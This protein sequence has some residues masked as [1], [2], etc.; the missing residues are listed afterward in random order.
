MTSSR[1]NLVCSG[2]RGSFGPARLDVSVPAP[3][4]NAGQTLHQ[5]IKAGLDIDLSA[6]ARLR[7]VYQLN[8]FR[9]QDDRQFGD[10]RLPVIP[11]HLYRAELRLGADA[12]N[13]A[14]SLEWVPQGVWADYANSLRTSGYVLIGATGEVRMRPG[15]TLFFNACDLADRKAVGAVSAVVDLSLSPAARRAI[16][17]P[18]E[19]R[20]VFAGLPWQLK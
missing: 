20:A 15:P 11:K 9:F 16:F 1:P 19:R 3:T 18:V 6:W 12:L 2:D 7:Q 5:G 10:N 17:Y 4:F 8:D 13:L 14:P